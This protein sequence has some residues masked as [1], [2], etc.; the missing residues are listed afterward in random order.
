MIVDNSTTVTP[1][2]PL[3][4]I[5]YHQLSFTLNKF[6]IFM[7]VDDSFHRLTTCTIEHTEIKMAGKTP[8]LEENDKELSSSDELESDDA[9]LTLEAHA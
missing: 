4:I 5:G 2:L 6:K 9:T 8:R 3:T 1:V 7:I